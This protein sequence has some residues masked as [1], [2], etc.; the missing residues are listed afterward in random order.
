MAALHDTVLGSI[1]AIIPNMAV[2][3][4]ALLSDWK[5]AVPK[6]DVCIALLHGVKDRPDG[7]ICTTKGAAPVKHVLPFFRN[8]SAVFFIQCYAGA[9]LL[10]AMVKHTAV[11][12]QV[13]ILADPDRQALLVS[14]YLGTLLQSMCMWA[15]NKASLKD[16]LAQAYVFLT[17]P[18]TRLT[19]SLSLLYSA[20]SMSDARI[21]WV[22]NGVATVLSFFRPPACPVCS[23][24]WATNVPRSQCSNSDCSF[25]CHQ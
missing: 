12:D 25:V 9:D 18:H 23:H 11:T 20:T 19:L 13:L 10:P 8:A 17:S 7:Y 2:R 5:L 1:S 6:S 3:Q 21:W 14:S 22:Q 15:G 24:I 4:Y 16:S